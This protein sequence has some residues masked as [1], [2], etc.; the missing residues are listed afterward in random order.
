MGRAN[1][2]W[3]YTRWG[4]LPHRAF[5]ML[6]FMALITRDADVTP[7]Y[8]GGRD[9]LAE[10]IGAKPDQAGY[11]AVKEVLRT[12]RTAG[13]ITQT[14]AGSRGRN[15]EY[16]LN[17]TGKLGGVSDTPNPELGG[18]SDTPYDSGKGGSHTPPNLGVRGGLRH[19]IGGVSDP[20]TVVIEDLKQTQ[21]HLEPQASQ[22]PARRPATRD[23]CP[24]H[25]DH[26]AG[27]CDPCEALTA[28][29]PPTLRRKRPTPTP[30]E[31]AS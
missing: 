3:I 31:R 19:P 20:P 27:R 18:V 29:P 14:R 5:R 9:P 13:A 11:D 10:A 2:E 8:Y 7:C 21:Q 23:M 28:P 22:L 24:D 25:P 15:A 30:E 1:A 17:V 16:A 4:H 12:L 6:V 26:P